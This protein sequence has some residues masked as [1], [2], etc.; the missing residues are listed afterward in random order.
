MGAEGELTGKGPYDCAG[1]FV[2][3]AFLSP[4]VKEALSDP[5][6]RF[7]HK[8]LGRAFNEMNRE[9]MSADKPAPFFTEGWA[10][11]A[12]AYVARAAKADPPRRVRMGSGLAPWQLRR[13][14]EMLCADL[15]ED[16][17]VK[18]VAKTCGLSVC[19]FTRGFRICTGKPPHEWLVGTRIEAARDLLA[20]SDMPLAEIAV[21]CGFSD[22]SHFSRVFRRFI[23]E[24]PAAWRREQKGAW[25]AA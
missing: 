9:L 21:M 16:V 22:Q 5:I 13:A 11:Q 23:D 6:C 18:S 4:T 2:D 12:L 8:A 1:L 15:S 7:E 20:K 25:V 17:S 19:Q 10:M 24:S 14:K 3:P